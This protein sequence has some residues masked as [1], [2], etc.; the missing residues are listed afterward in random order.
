MTTADKTKQKLL[1]SMRKS[2]TG[3]ARKPAA[4]TPASATRKSPARRA[5]KPAAPKRPAA[6]GTSIPSITRQVSSDPFQSN[7]RIW[8]D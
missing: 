3:A 5:A 7:G 4:A 1:D 8:P 2:K 6:A